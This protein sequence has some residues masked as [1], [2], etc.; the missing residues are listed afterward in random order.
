LAT[1]ENKVKHPKA[2]FTIEYHLCHI[3]DQSILAAI[4]LNVSFQVDIYFT[5]TPFLIS[6]YSTTYL[7]SYSVV[8]FGTKAQGEQ[9]MKN[10]T[11]GNVWLNLN[12]PAVN[13]IIRVNVMNK[14]QESR[15]V[16]EQHCHW[17]IQ[18]CDS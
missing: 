12:N 13:V 3:D 18:N 8:G 7:Y 5:L 11:F 1:V 17:Q 10:R 15:M 16:L 14:D 9:T 4:V 6:L 2:C